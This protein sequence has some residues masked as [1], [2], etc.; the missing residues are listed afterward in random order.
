MISAWSY[1]DG[2]PGSTPVELGAIDEVRRRPGTLIWIDASGDAGDALSDVAADLGVN[3]LALEDVVHGDQRTK[4]ERY[5]SHFQIAAHDCVLVDHHVH[6]REVDVL[7]GEGWILTIR[8]DTGRGVGSGPDGGTGAAHDTIAEARRR[9]ERQRE[10]RGSNDEGFVLWAVLDVIVDRYFDVIDT[11][12]GSLEDLEEIVFEGH[13]GEATPREVF[14]LRRAMVTFRRAAA[15]LREV[16]AQML[17]R[18]V[19]VVGDA[20]LMHLQDVYDHVLRVADLV[21][22]Q[23]D[24]LTG[25]LEAHLAV[26]SNRMNQVMKLTSS[27]GAIILGSTLIAGVYG[28]NF[29]HMPELHWYL[30]YPMALGMMVL[31]TFV[32]YRMFRG[33]GWL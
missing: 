28:M 5:G 6:V 11:I 2:E 32:L 18:E 10:E 31:L 23:R 14:A 4:L 1:T 30:G 21:E 19:E 20:A 16:I 24:V 7:F 22:S 26:A 3:P 12:D 9:Y 33:R 29:R 25:L 27:W 15:P 8:H 13:T 17:R